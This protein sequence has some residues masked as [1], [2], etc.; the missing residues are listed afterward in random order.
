MCNFNQMYGGLQRH[1]YLCCHHK[2]HS[3]F[4][5]RGKTMERFGDSSMEMKDS[6]CQALAKVNPGKVTPQTGKKTC[7]GICSLSNSLP[8]QGGQRKKVEELMSAVN[9]NSSACSTMKLYPKMVSQSIKRPSEVNKKNKIGPKLI[10]E[11]EQGQRAL[12]KAKPKRKKVIG[13]KIIAR[14]TAG[15]IEQCPDDD[16]IW[17]ECNVPFRINIPFPISM[18]NLFGPQAFSGNRNLQIFK[19]LVPTRKF[20]RDRK[21]EC[22][23]QFTMCPALPS[24]DPESDTCFKA[25]K[26][27]KKKCCRRERKHCPCEIST[28][29]IDEES[30][31]VL[32]CLEQIR[33]Q[34]ADKSAENQEKCIYRCFAEKST[35]VKS[36]QK[37]TNKTNMENIKNS[38]SKE[39]H[40]EIMDKKDNLKISKPESIQKISPTTSLNILA[41]PNPQV[42]KLETK[43]GLLKTQSKSDSIP[44]EEPR[45]AEKEKDLN[46]APKPCA[47]VTA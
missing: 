13:K 44:S 17:F 39:T 12:V 24:P 7:K 46:Y 33:N 6:R 9:L 15:N 47:G 45:I 19:A 30:D 22:P 41:Q 14:S 4:C 36:I 18:K 40:Q 10:P 29:T 37:H 11:L 27:S 38:P 32:C 34:L 20:Q 1:N 35:S 21:S 3:C 16:G 26:F 43:K 2:L 31:P 5:K 8:S 28:Q 42:M 25:T 23:F